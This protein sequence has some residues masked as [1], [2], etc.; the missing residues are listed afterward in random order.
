[1]CCFSCNQW[2]QQALEAVQAGHVPLKIMSA[3]CTVYPAGG[4]GNV[5]EEIL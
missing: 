4:S 3:V 1:M 2:R 5:G